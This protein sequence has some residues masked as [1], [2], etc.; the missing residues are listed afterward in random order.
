MTYLTE[1]WAVPWL[2]FLCE[3]SLR[4]GLL[5]AALAVW[6]ILRPPRH[7][8]TRHL[9]CLMAL[10]AGVLLPVAP[11]WSVAVPWAPPATRTDDVA[12]IA[13]PPP[14][15][16]SDLSDAPVFVTRSD[17]SS[18]PDPPPARP[19]PRI[20]TVAAAFSVWQ[21]AAL[22]AAVAWLTVVLVLLTRLTGARIK[23]AVIKSGAVAMGEGADRLLGECRAAV[24]LSRPVG[25][26]AHPAVASPV[27]VG[28]WQ[29][30]VLVP[31]DWVDWPEP[32]R[33]ACLLHELS[34]LARYDDWAKLAQ[35]LIRTPFF[36]HP[37]ISWL[38]AR[39]DR[40][41]ELLCDETVVAHGS[42]PVAFARLLLDLTRRPRFLAVTPASRPGWLPFIDHHTIAIR[43][44]RLL[45]DDMPRSLSRPSASRSFILGTLALSVALGIGGLRVRAVSVEPAEQ[46]PRPKPTEPA[47]LPKPAAPAAVKEAPHEIRGV[48]VDHEGHPIAGATIVAGVYDSGRSGHQTVTSDAVGRFTWPV[49]PGSVLVCVYVHKDGF[50]VGGLLV[51]AA[52]SAA[53]NDLKIQLD[54][55]VPFAAT[56]VD[57]DRKPVSGAQ[58][59]IDMIARA[60]EQKD[61]TR[62]NVG[63]GY[64]YIRREVLKGSLAESLYETRTDAGGSFAF[65]AIGP[66]SGLKL[67]VTAANGRV[68]LVRPGSNAVGLAHRT[69]Q[70]QGFVTAGPGEKNRFVAVPAARVAGR[71]VTKLPGVI[72][73]GLT[74]HY[75]ASREPGVYRPTTNFG[76]EVKTDAEGRFAFE[77]LGEGTIN[78]FVQGDGGKEDWTYRA[79]ND[80]P[81]T[82]GK[83]SE[84]AIELIRGVQV[85][86]TV[87]AQGTGEPIAGAQVSVFGPSRPLTGALMAGA[88][89]DDRG[90]Y[91]YRLP[92]GETSFYVTGPLGRYTRLSGEGSSRT[93]TI[94]DRALRYEVPPIELAAA[95]TVRGRVLDATGK[96]IAGAKVVGTCEGGL[97]RPF[98]GADTITDARGEFRLL[99]GLNNTVAIGKPARLLIRLRDGTEHEAAAVPAA[100]GA[101]TIKLPVTEAAP[102]SVEGPRDVAEDELAGV[103][104]DIDGKPIAGAEVDAWTWYPGNEA[105]TDARGAFRIRSLDKGRKVEVIV[106]KDRYSPQLFLTQPTG[107]PGWVI[108]L[109]NK[110]YFE[111]RVTGPDGKSVIGARVRANNGPKRADGVMISEIWTEATT[112]VDG[113]YRLYAQPD[114]YDIHVRAPGVGAARLPQTSLDPDESKRLDI[115]LQPAVAFHAK[116]VDSLTGAPVPGVRL[117]HWQHPGVEGRSGNDG[118]AVVPDL[119]PGPFNFQVDAPKGYARWWSNQAS[120]EW[121]RRKIDATRGGWQRNFDRLDFALEFGM[122]PVTIVVER[123]ATVSGQVLDPDGKPVAG[124]TVAPALTGTGNSLTGDTRFSVETNKDGRFT[125]VLPAGGDREYNLVAHDGKYGHWR[126]WANG[127]LPPIRTKPGDVL[128]DLELRLTRPATVRGRVTDSDGRPVPGREVRASAADRL[129]NRYYDPTIL[130]AA[131]G[132][133]ELKFIRPGEQFVQVGPFWLDAREAPEG[134]SHT[135]TLAQ[136]ESRAGIDFRVAKSDR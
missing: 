28:G 100:D 11:R 3:W 130:T 75:Q 46:T 102:S 53:A 129:E 92:P 23:L 107:T 50:A 1:R 115:R 22:S 17:D 99:P 26:A 125:S 42:D 116:V 132:T 25:L 82:A 60:T 37:M 47:A 91:H 43:I 117:W 24:G 29:P 56:L 109:G 127:V 20:S 31:P 6:L 73:S 123:G 70:D 106:R 104:V 77:G 74:A 80:I 44:E 18:R 14:A 119:M 85:E 111:G 49:P 19:A 76:A 58:V 134:T 52:A 59:R 54:K 10:T 41:R 35:E 101:V 13:A 21:I 89:T 16:S 65:G 84:V 133:Y 131:D 7:A 51:S 48:V 69:M 126:S 34:H 68:L 63:T 33:R 122:P 61:G 94:S 81:L 114:V 103:V 67:A 9:L 110:T 66:D 40:E 83:T 90:R 120:S 5:V 105:R 78:V 71:V 96:P 36:F 124:A 57:G 98:G 12:D 95:V 55:P 62:T 2:A 128:R 136:G 27:V 135:L 88:T 113:R 108:V 39:L 15:S 87:V 45:E 30:V 64:T 38:L 97:C 79:A 4:W 8:A 118:F 72:V 93:E 86:G 32:H 112:G 121:S